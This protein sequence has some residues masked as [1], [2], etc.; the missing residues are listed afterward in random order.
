MASRNLNKCPDGSGPISYQW[1]RKVSLCLGPYS[2]IDIKYGPHLQ[3]CQI[4]LALSHI[5]LEWVHLPIPITGNGTT[6]CLE[7]PY[8]KVWVQMSSN[9]RRE[10]VPHTQFIVYDSALP[11]LSL[12]I[13]G[14]LQP[15]T[16]FNFISMSLRFTFLSLGQSYGHEATMDAWYIC[17]EMKLWQCWSSQYIKPVQHNTKEKHVCIPCIIWQDE[18]E[19]MQNP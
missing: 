13:K 1:L 2:A 4:N 3:I 14:D 8:T 5:C 7:L 17:N 11:C 16:S 6:L 9:P 10:H 12:C 15:S 19:L 18:S